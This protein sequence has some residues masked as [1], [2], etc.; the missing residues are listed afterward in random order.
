ME[1]G[2]S[3]I[4][5]AVLCMSVSVKSRLGGVVMLSSVTGSWFCQWRA[6]LSSSSAQLRGVA[7]LLAGMP[8]GLL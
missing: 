6:E 5:V 1:A 8:G 3:A 4:D 2:L 7:R